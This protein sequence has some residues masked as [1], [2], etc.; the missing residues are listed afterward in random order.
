MSWARCSSRLPS[1]PGIES[2]SVRLDDTFDAREPIQVGSHRIRDF[3]PQRRILNAREVI[4]HSSNIGGR[5]AWP[6]RWAARR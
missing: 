3:R 2:G 5:P 4:I 1:R 6:N